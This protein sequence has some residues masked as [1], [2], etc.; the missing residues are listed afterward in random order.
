GLQRVGNIIV[1][2]RPRL[3]DAPACS[4]AAGR[5]AQP[6]TVRDNG[7]RNENNNFVKNLRK[8]EKVENT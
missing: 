1:C 6:P 8:W 3:C 7:Q 5:C 4:Q 2:S